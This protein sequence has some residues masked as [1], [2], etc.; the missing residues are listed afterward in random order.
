MYKKIDEKDIAY[1]SSLFDE[2]YFFTRDNIPED[3]NN[4]K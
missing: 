3:N 1:L 4:H 2:K